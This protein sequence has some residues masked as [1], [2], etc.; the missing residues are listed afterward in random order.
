MDLRE[1]LRSV[2]EEATPAS[3]SCKKV[4]NPTFHY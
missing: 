3:N 2:S 1:I 4:A